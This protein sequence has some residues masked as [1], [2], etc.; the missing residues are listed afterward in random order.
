[1]RLRTQTLLAGAAT[2]VVPLLGWQVVRELDA[3]LLEGRVAAQEL[4]AANLRAALAAAV[5]G[6]DVLA[7]RLRLGRE[8]RAAE[9]LYAIGLDAPLVVDGYDEDWPVAR[10]D[11]ATRYGAASGSGP[12]PSPVP[13]VAVRAAVHRGALFVSVDADDPTPA[14]HRPPAPRP[15]A[16]ELEGPSADELRAN[17][18]AFELF[19]SAPDG[20]RRHALLSPTAPGALP[21]LA[22]SDAPPGVAGPRA[23][24]A[25]RVLP[26]WDAAWQLRPGGWR[27]ELALPAPPAGSLIGLAAVDAP[28]GARGGEGRAARAW[29]GTLAPSRMRALRRDGSVPPPALPTLYRPAPRLA[30]VVRPRVGPGTRVRLFDAGGRLLAD[31]D[32]LNLPGDGTADEGDDGDGGPFASLWDAALFRVF[33]WLVAGDLPLP[34]ERGSPIRPLHLD[35]A[36]AAFGA[37]S[38]PGDAAASGA[39]RRYVTAERDRVIGTLERFGAGDASGLM[40]VESNEEHSSAYNGARLARL[41]SLL[42]LASALA[43]AVALAWSTRLSLRL[44]ALSRDAARAVDRDGRVAG[45]AGRRSDR[46]FSERS[47]GR[48]GRQRAGVGPLASARASDELGELSRDLSALLERSAAYTD[49]LE[50][51]SSRLSHELGTPLA[52][53]R[54]ALENLER[55]RLDPESAALVA[56]AERGADQLRALLRALAES[57][58]LDGALDRAERA[59]L[60]LDAFVVDC[61]TRYAHA[62]PGTRVTLRRTLAPGSGAGEAVPGESAPGEPAPGMPVRA[63]VAPEPLLQALDKLVDNAVDFSVDG[64]VELVLAPLGARASDAGSD[65]DDEGRPGRRRGARRTGRWGGRWG[66]RRGARRRRRDGPAWLLGVSNRGRP[67]DP[68]VAARLFEPM[69]GT[70]AGGT[71]LG[72]GL[73]VVRLVAELHGG[74]PWVAEHPPVVTIG[75]VLPADGIG[76]TGPGTTSAEG[77]G[78][79]PDDRFDDPAYDR[80]AGTGSER[81]GGKR[82]GR[83]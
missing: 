27:A 3:S 25:G 54:G 2:L 58:R 70:R 67:L 16:G 62:Y 9:E 60:D 15:D 32:R 41:F 42:V 10:A 82:M 23:E 61:A 43:T 21:T 64:E 18:D 48:A 59:T 52:V 55:D 66:G 20:A 33:A 49:Y 36:V 77:A 37:A 1:M 26:R 78:A 45:R 46:R 79:D 68:E 7:A 5:T 6:D 11:A 76:G 40:L 22:G 71:H 30:A 4:A 14:W 12:D 75:L 72:L 74:R 56:R 13:G 24:R 47:A 31:V 50:A 29:R 39:T 69:F 19:V 34:L 51:L 53:V 81:R 80:R 83:A 44:R 17:G 73:H 35:A 63:T 65:A 38:G 28:D 57:A 8:P